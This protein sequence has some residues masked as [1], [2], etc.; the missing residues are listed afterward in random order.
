LPSDPRAYIIVTSELPRHPKFKALSRSARL[1]IIELWCHCREFKTDGFID[2][3]T[4]GEVPPKE[5]KELLGGWVEAREDGTLWC[6]DYLDHQKSKKQLEALA[7]KRAEGGTFGA[8][9]KH[10]ERKGV[11]NPDC[12]FCPD[13]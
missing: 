9:V 1:R 6:H 3:G 2:A 5:R 10:H 11:V 4:W 12:P 7:T 13:P 8:H